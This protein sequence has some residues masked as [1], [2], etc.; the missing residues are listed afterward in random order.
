MHHTKYFVADV[1]AHQQ[2]ADFSL[3]GA[4]K[5]TSKAFQYLWR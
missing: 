5:L 2:S 3:P 4:A 1:L